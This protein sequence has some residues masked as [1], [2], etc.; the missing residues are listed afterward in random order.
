VIVIV[1]GDE[2]AFQP[3]RY[4]AENCHS[5]DSADQAKQYFLPK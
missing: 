3:G 2:P 4:A 1:I 5:D